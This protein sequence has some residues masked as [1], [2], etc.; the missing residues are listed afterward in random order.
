MW[1]VAPYE[2]IPANEEAESVSKTLE[3][4]YDDACIA[5]LAS[6]LGRR[7][8]ERE[9][10]RRSGFWR[11]LVDPETLFMRGRGA[12]GSRVSPF[13]PVRGGHLQS[14]YTEGNAWQYSW[15]VPHDV[16]GLVAAVGG[17]DAFVRRLDSLFEQPAVAGEGT[18][19]DV[20]GLIGQYAHG[21]E[22]SHH[23]AYL[24][25]WAGAHWRT[26]ERVRHIVSTLYHA[27]PDGLCGNEDCG[28]LS[29]WLVLSAIGF[30]PVDPASG[31]YVLGAPHFERVELVLPGARRLVVSA[32]GL[33]RDRSW[34]RGARLNGRPLERCWVTHQ[35][36]VAGGELEFV[37]GAAP[38]RGWAARSTAPPSVL[39]RAP[40]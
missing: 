39:D 22:P 3:Y 11:Q 33:S 10:V 6:R 1:P 15:Y 38:D 36:L 30:Y 35:E 5:S 20:T 4:A 12:D 31:V 23:I 13:S 19:V 26:Q 32:A 25:A 27:G 17:A 9:F 34:V 21:N 8:V 2:Y 40:R 18:P 29:A 16:P 28:Q 14:E 37:V 24:Y 7:D